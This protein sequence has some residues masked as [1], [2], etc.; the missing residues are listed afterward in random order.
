MAPP[1]RPPLS[2]S[3]LQRCLAAVAVTLA[4]LCGHG[5]GG[6]ELVLATATATQPKRPASSYMLWLTENR[7]KIVDKLGTANV[8]AVGKA[9]GQEWTGLSA[10]QKKKF[11]KKASELKA[12]Y[13]AAMEEFIA[14]GGVKKTSRK[15]STS[16]MA[17]D[18]NA[19][20][21]PPS[22]YLL[23]LTENRAKIVADLPK[24]HKPTE[25][26]T[27][28]GARWRKATAEQ[29]KEYE[30]RAAKLKEEYTASM[31][32]YVPPA[33]VKTAATKKGQKSGVKRPPSAY[34]LWLSDNRGAIAKSLPD[35]KVTDI[36][37]EAGVR[38]KKVS[39][40]TKKKY[41]DMYAKKKEEYKQKLEEQTV[42]R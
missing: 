9:A 3:V 40:A 26:M 39:A 37:K 16:K 30:T 6:A 36:A 17:K 19:P 35:A 7:K 38:W 25:V 29:K 20:K 2:R 42:A 13:A 23:W 14:K 32:T 1:P 31:N 4:F 18:P 33:S 34:M 10:A 21:R 27:E 12:K 24:G 11:E 28:G 22:A 15:R 5:D 41:E 8:A